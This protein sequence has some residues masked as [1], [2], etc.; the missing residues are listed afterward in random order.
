MCNDICYFPEVTCGLSIT[1]LKLCL[2]DYAD[3]L[4]H[5]ADGLLGAQASFHIV[6]INAQTP[7]MLVSDQK[8]I[9]AISGSKRLVRLLRCV[10]IDN[11]A[12]PWLCHCRTGEHITFVVV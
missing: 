4:I 6:L 9:C 8:I 3:L 7:L 11:K 1:I 10:L 12:L 2:L 5:L